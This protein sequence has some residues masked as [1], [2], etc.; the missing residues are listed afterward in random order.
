[1]RPMA[2][3]FSR[4][5]GSM[6]V[7]RPRPYLGRLWDICC[8]CCSWT[9]AALFHHFLKQRIALS[10]S[11][12]ISK[13]HITK[14]ERSTK[15]IEPASHRRQLSIYLPT[16]PYFLSPVHLPLPLSLPQSRQSVKGST[17]HDKRTLCIRVINQYRKS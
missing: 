5:E 11:I 16:Q 2:T 9:A 17:K 10:E 8:A 4:T 1:M 3:P 7:P 12:V 13:S 6:L 15:C 14:T